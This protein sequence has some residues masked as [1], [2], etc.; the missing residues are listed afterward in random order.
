MVS[1]QSFLHPLP[2]IP[3]DGDVSFVA[4]Y[5]LNQSRLVVVPVLPSPSV[6]TVTCKLCVAVLEYKMWSFSVVCSGWW[7]YSRAVDMI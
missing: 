1:S 6:K 3:L 2:P 5:M 7:L 4:L